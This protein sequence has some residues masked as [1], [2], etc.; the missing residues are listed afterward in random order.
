VIRALLTG[1]KDGLLAHKEFNHFRTSLHHYIDQLFG[2]SK[3]KRRAK[4]PLQR[5][6]GIESGRPGPSGSASVTNE[7][8]GQFGKIMD[9]QR[10]TRQKRA[11]ESH[12]P[13][14]SMTDLQE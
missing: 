2:H 11:S 4:R 3:S 13:T 14:A 6:G 7:T 10:N 9:Q 5:E 8:L 1:T 12:Y